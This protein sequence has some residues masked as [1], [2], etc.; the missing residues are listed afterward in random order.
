MIKT[1]LRLEKVINSKMI[2]KWK[3]TPVSSKAKAQPIRP[4]SRSKD[5]M[6]Y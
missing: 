6:Y 2:K 5:G 4:D 1:I 3:V